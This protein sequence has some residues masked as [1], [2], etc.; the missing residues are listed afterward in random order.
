MAMALPEQK[1]KIVKAEVAIALQTEL[2]RLPDEDE[3]GRICLLTRVMYEIMLGL[4]YWRKEQKGS[5]QLPIYQRGWHTILI[6]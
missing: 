1:E 4:S 2:G 3:V 6:C 5:G